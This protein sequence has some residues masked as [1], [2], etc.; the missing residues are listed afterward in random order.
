MLNLIVV[1]SSF[2]DMWFECHYDVLKYYFSI[3]KEQMPGFTA[4]TLRQLLQ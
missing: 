4:E 3:P 2:T 1:C